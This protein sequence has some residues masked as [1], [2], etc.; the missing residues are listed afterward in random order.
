MFQVFYPALT[1]V[2]NVSNV[3]EPDTIYPITY[4]SSYTRAAALAYTEEL[5]TA[6]SYLSGLNTLATTLKVGIVGGGTDEI[7]TKAYTGGV[8][9]P[10]QNRIYFCPAAQATA[11]FDNW[12]YIDCNTGAVVPYESVTKVTGVGTTKRDSYDG[13]VFDPVRNRIYFTPYAQSN[14]DDWHYIDCNNGAI[15]KITKPTVVGANAYRGGGSYSPTQQRIYFPP[16]VQGNE[17]IWHY[18]DCVTATTV[19]FDS[20]NVANPG[21]VVNTA[22]WGSVYS[23]TQNRIYLV[24]FSQFNQPT[25]HYIDCNDGTVVGYAAPSAEMV[26]N[27]IGGVYSPT[28]NRIYFVPLGQ[29]TGT[30]W[31]YIDCNDGSVGSYLSPANAVADAYL[32]GCYSPVDNRIYFCPFQQANLNANPTTATKWH[33][34]NCDDGSVGEYD[35]QYT[36]SAT[37]PV[38]FRGLHYSPTLNRMYFIPYELNTTV[39][40]TSLANFYFID[41]QSNA[42]TSKVLMAR[43]E[44]NK[45]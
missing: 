22:Y 18:I 3:A 37:V 20:P 21:S 10:S 29:S 40:S 8:Y 13:G 33:Y 25:W 12:H 7:I 6:G 16:Y 11:V 19:A 31:H 9:S 32:C 2:S 35:N 26:G 38:P 42:P 17:N 36:S 30:Y 1:K 5:A 44:F 15:G 41:L 45:F 39:P 4:T 14:F 24:P 27:Y 23:P 43:S 28:Q 34:I